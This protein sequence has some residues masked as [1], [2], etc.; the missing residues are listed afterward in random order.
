[1]QKN[2]IKYS[3]FTAQSFEFVVAI[4]MLC[5]WDWRNEKKE[6]K[7]RSVSN[8]HVPIL[9]YAYYKQQIG[10]FVLIAVVSSA[11]QEPARYPA[12]VDPSLCPG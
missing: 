6:K 10:F 8:E 1:M 9:F 2:P 3:K 11:P 5:F 7:F 4:I 12:G